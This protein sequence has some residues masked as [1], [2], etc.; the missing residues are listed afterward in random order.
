MPLDPE[1]SKRAVAYLNEKWS[2]AHSCPICTANDWNVS[3]IVELRPFTGGN[4]VVGGAVYPLLQVVCNNCGYTL[5]LNAI[6]AG[7]VGPAAEATP[8]AQATADVP[9][10]TVETAEGSES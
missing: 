6:I 4:L 7:L 8:P 9:D 10:P 3:E 1:Q 5:L 2:T